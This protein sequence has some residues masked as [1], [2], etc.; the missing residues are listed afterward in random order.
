MPTTQSAR[1]DTPGKLGIL[2]AGMGAIASTL[3][4]GVEAVRMGTGRPLGSLT[5][6]ALA[7][8]AT[9][10]NPQ[11][12]Y[13][14]LNLN[15]IQDLVFGGWDITPGTVFDSATRA[16]V[17]D[18][19]LLERLRPGLEAVEPM[20]GI[21]DPR[22]LR[23]AEGKRL[24]PESNKY[25]QAEALRADIRAFKKQHRLDQVVVMWCGST[26]V[27]L[28]PGPAHQGIGIFETA[29]KEN[30]ASIAPSMIYAYAALRENCGFVNA[31]PTLSVD[32]PVMLELAAEHHAPVSG[33]DLKTGQTWLKTV[34]APGIKQRMLGLNGWFS[35]N[36]LGNQD[37]A[38]LDDPAAFRSKE[39]SK[40]S[41][42]NHILQP[43]LYP[44]LYGQMSHQVKINYYPPRGDNK[45]SWDTIDILGWL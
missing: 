14:Y 29:M 24:K 3:V 40:L 44:E 26:E 41:A 20:P 33:K 23:R 35:M 45:E 4:A 12:L 30:E 43:E 39:E 32:L 13:E 34:L 31:T 5:Q 18:P 11:K 17:L 37:G 15:R 36:I 28:T 7:P 6:L 10:R 16:E 1:T 8:G 27:F 38:V 22:Y 25:A 21:H 9:T 42:L 2:M 19:A